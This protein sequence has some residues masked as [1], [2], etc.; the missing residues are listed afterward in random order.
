MA[1]KN[2]LLFAQPKTNAQARI[3]LLLEGGREGEEKE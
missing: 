2:L 3:R 1:A